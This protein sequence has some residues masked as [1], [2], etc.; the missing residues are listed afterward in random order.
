MA[1]A[2]PPIAFAPPSIGQAEIDEVTSTLRSG[3]LSSGPRVRAFESAFA[4]YIGV[5][6]AVAVN[7]G[8]AALH[9][10]LL[11]AKVGPGHEVV[12][13]PLTFCSTANV[14]VHVGATPRFADIDPVTWNLS[15]TAVEAAL[16]PNT[17]AI[18]RSKTSTLKFPTGGSWRSLVLPAAVSRRSC[19]VS[20]A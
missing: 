14:V 17:R 11:A 7:S 20:T 13:T 18:M 16:T 1:T 2:L 19:A 15:P 4:S 10:A 6:H 3:W 5:P 8:T 12:T 9:L